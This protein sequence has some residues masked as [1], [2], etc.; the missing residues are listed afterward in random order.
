MRNTSM[1]LRRFFLL[2]VYMFLFE[3]ELVISGS[4]FLAAESGASL[5]GEVATGSDKCRQ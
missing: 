2:A 1:P 4:F 5:V 3:F